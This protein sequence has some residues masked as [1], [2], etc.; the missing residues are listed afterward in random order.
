M[1]PDFKW[2]GVRRV[3]GG[4]KRKKLY[5]R[6]TGGKGQPRV[7]GNEGDEYFLYARKISDIQ[8]SIF[9]FKDDYKD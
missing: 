8:T 2:I 3:Q 6:I 4:H 7:F 1:F 9:I 5:K